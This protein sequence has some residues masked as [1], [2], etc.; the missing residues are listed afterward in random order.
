MKLC[1]GVRFIFETL[2]NL[3]RNHNKSVLVSSKLNKGSTRST[4]GSY[5]RTFLEAAYREI[6]IHSTEA[7]WEMLARKEWLVCR[8]ETSPMVDILGSTLMWA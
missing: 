2:N 1:L 4:I 7:V 3:I 5:G 8:N 6:M